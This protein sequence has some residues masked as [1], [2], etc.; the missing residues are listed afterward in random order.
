MSNT[1]NSTQIIWDV[2]TREIV[3]IFRGTVVPLLER[4]ET[5][6]AGM[7]AAEQVCRNAGWAVPA[8]A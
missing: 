8:V 2:I 3:V 5:R 1:E 6:E 4:F 7:R